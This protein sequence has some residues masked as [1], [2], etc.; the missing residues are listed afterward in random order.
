MRDDTSVVMDAHTR[1][2]EHLSARTPAMAPQLPI[3]PAEAT[4]TSD[5]QVYGTTWCSLTYRVREYLMHARL[6]YRF[7]DI[8]HDHRADEFVLS[9]MNG[10]RRFPLVVVGDDVIPDPT[11]SELRRVLDA[12]RI[13][14]ER[15]RPRRE[16]IP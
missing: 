6:T 3:L 7:L 14:P 12:H 9:A 16:P 1:R 11:I 4:V 8:D 2:E 10:R 5:I 13:G 15:H